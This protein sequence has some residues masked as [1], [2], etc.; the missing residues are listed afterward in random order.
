M[1]G[2]FEMQDGDWYA[3]VCGSWHRARKRVRIAWE[4]EEETRM[5]E[6]VPGRGA[7]KMALTEQRR[8]LYACIDRA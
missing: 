8:W 5:D 3:R 4:R 1:G 6:L 2:F 7:G